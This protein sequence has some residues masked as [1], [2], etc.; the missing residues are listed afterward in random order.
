MRTTVTGRCSLAAAI[1]EKSNRSGEGLAIISA[2][3][4]RFAVAVRSAKEAES[5]E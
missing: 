4:Y 1:Q 2:D 5:A 3:L